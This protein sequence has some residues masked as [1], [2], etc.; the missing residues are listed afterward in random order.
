MAK[1]IVGAHIAP[2]QPL[3][4]AETLGADCVQIFL[5]DPQSFKKPPPRPDADELRA[6]DVA[7]YIHAPYLINVCSPKRNIR[8]GSRKILQETCDAA[9]A[10]GAA[11]VIVHGGHADDDVDEGFGRWVRTLE[12]LKSEV[13]VF[14]ENTPGGKNA[15]A[16]LFDDLARLWE[17]IGKKP[18]SYPIGL[19]FDTCH[20]HAA[21]EQLAD[22]VERVIAI[23]GK[24]DLVH[25]NDSKDEAGRGRDR[26]TN[27][28][29]GTID[30]DV[31]R[32]MIS[33]AKAPV[34]CETPGSIEDLEADLAFVRAAIG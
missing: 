17:S 33:A 16:R 34:V 7:V 2:D 18:P 9:A 23:T 25:A 20:A 29:H 4:I 8:F 15:V 28:G 26:H 1:Q 14:I 27:L 11:A 30:P 21:G 10:I 12:I 3:K 13:P 6:S 31:L 32:H 24:I 5:S 19:C 22:A